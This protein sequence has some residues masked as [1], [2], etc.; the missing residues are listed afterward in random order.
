MLFNFGGH[1]G[2]L[3]FKKGE[4][5]FSNGKLSG[6]E[7]VV[8][9]TTITN[10]DG[11]Y[12][13]DLVG[14]LKNEDFF[15]VP[16]FPTSKLNITKVEYY[17]NGIIRMDA[18]LTIKGITNPVVFESTLDE[19]KNLLKSRMKIDRTDWN[20]VYG[21]KGHVNVKDYAISDAIELEVEIFY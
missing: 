15:N 21:A 3:K 16:S 18:E 17:N 2:T 9:M 5:T 11:D 4:L 1:Y 13:P 7:F 10:T 19:A 12:S 8:D 6:G 20:I 14:H